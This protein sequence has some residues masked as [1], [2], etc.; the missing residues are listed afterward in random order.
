MTWLHGETH[1]LNLVSPEMCIVHDH[2]HLWFVLLWF[3]FSASFAESSTKRLITIEVHLSIARCSPIFSDKLKTWLHKE[4][5]L[6]N[7]EAFVLKPEC[8]KTKDILILP[9][10][11]SN[12]LH[13][14]GVSQFWQCQDF[15][16]NLSEIWNEM[17][18]T[19][20]ELRQCNQNGHVTFVG[21][22]ISYLRRQPKLSLHSKP[23]NR[24]KP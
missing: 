21:A 24:V 12:V 10:W 9:L 3:C 18:I 15:E 14:E 6:L 4:T 11:K 19:N 22:D 1:F 13:K 2:N 20:E 23:S 5:Q 16:S 7:L 8:T 17:S